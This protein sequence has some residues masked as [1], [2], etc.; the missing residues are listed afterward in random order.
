[1]FKTVIL[2]LML[3]TTLA[4][5][6][7]RTDI[8]AD[9]DHNIMTPTT[10][11]LNQGELS[12]NSYELFFA[13]VSYGV[14]DEFQ[15]TFTTLLPI[16]SGIPFVGLFTGK[17]RLMQSDTMAFAVQP[18]ALIMSKD[19]DTIG[20]IN[21]TFMLDFLLNED[22]VI[23]LSQ[24]NN[25]P[26]A[27]NDMM[28]GFLFTITAAINS[29]V[30]EHVKLVAELTMGGSYYDGS[31]DMATDAMLFNYGVRFF[32]GDLA[33]LL[34]FIRPISSGDNTFLMGFPYV[35]FTAKF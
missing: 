15:L 24:S 17:Y 20:S 4:F 31:F 9:A 5:A 25:I 21:L 6:G 12:F 23:T 19:G 10:A 28:S 14:T 8:D 16:V 32:T 2:S 1:M 27:N 35:T 18:G 11:T 34:S 30:S 29:R 13:G 7:T 26:F 3:I 33:A 22:N